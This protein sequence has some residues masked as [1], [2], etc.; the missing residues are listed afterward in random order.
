M[1]TST[2]NSERVSELSS[3]VLNRDFMWGVL[4]VYR[5]RDRGIADSGILEVSVFGN[6]QFL[7]FGP[8]RNLG[9]GDFLE[10]GSC[11]IPGIWDFRDF[12]D[13]GDLRNPGFPGFPGF[14]A[15]GPRAGGVGVLLIN[16]FFCGFSVPPMWERV[17]IL[18]IGSRS[19][20]NSSPPP[21]NRDFINFGQ[22]RGSP[23][24]AKTSAL[25]GSFGRKLPKISQP[26]GPGFFGPPGTPPRTPT[27]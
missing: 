1:G 14:P 4:E 24:I 27:M 15:T 5:S 7:D 26:F 9:I 3:G 25:T 22:N 12:R 21:P 2:E 11:G 16:V 13:S 17:R 10:S 8:W 19:A 20:T 6:S 18:I 23:K